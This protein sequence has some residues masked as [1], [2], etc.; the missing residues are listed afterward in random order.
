MPWRA[1]EENN[2]ATPQP[3]GGPGSNQH[4]TKPPVAKHDK[5]PS[6]DTVAV[7]GSAA[8][9]DPFAQPSYGSDEP[10]AQ[11]LADADHALSL[12][13]TDVEPEPLSPSRQARHDAMGSLGKATGALSGKPGMTNVEKA[14]TVQVAHNHAV[15]AINR[16]KDAQ[17]HLDPDGT[18]DDTAAPL[19]DVDQ[20]VAAA[21]D[22]TPRNLRK[23]G[24]AYLRAAAR[25]IDGREGMS[26]QDKA[27]NLAV[28][29]ERIT[30]S[31]LLLT[32]ACVKHHDQAKEEDE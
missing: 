5:A 7:T 8:T 25:R 3:Q 29:R 16:V 9:A 14:D 17:S 13:A 22:R 20:S 15:D 19:P 2:M 10:D 28:A 27:D 11:T 24:D 32:E 18:G 1:P 26:D 6:A 12:E 23:A 4:Q 31:L 30:R 21:E